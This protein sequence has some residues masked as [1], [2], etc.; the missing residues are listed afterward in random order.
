MRDKIMT[1]LRCLYACG[2]ATKVSINKINT[3]TG[4]GVGV[5]RHR[6]FWNPKKRVITMWCRVN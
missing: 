5:F 6:V 2:Y 3:K 1:S 4:S